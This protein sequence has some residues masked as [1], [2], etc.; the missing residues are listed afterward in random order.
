M[1]KEG[2]G[3]GS[4]DGYGGGGA[5]Q[6]PETRLWEMDL[7]AFIER[8]LSSSFN[9]PQALP[10]IDELFKVQYAEGCKTALKAC[11]EEAPFYEPGAVCLKAG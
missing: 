5:G 3:G 11:R 9:D 10:R 1:L 8:C 4:G 2:E 7:P 6:A